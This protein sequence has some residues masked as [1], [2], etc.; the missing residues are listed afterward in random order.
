MQKGFIAITALALGALSSLGLLY[1]TTSQNNELCQEEMCYEEKLGT[2]SSTPLT[3][4]KSGNV[5][6]LNDS[7]GFYVSSGQDVCIDGGACLSTGGGGGGFTTSSA[8]FW[9]EDTRQLG[10]LSDVNTTTISI[11]D[12]LIWSGTEWL[13]QAQSGGSGGS[14]WLFGADQT[15]ITPSTTVGII[16]NASSTLSETTFTDSV[17][18]K[19]SGNDETTNSLSIFNSDGDAIMGVRDNVNVGVGTT[20]PQSRLHV[21]TDGTANFRLQSTGADAAATMGF[22]GYEAGG[23]RTWSFGDSWNANYDIALIN[24]GAGGDLILR[25]NTGDGGEIHFKPQNIAAGNIDF[26]GDLEIIGELTAT[27]ASANS[28]SGNLQVTGSSDSY[29]SGA[30]LAVGDTSAGARL[31]VKGAGATS[32]TNAFRVEDSGDNP[33]FFIRDDGNVGI[34]NAIPGYKLEVTGTTYLDGDATTTAQLYLS[35]YDCSGYG[36]SGKLTVDANGHVICADDSGGGGG[37]GGWWTWS[38]GYL[39]P[40]TTTADVLIGAN[41][42]TTTAK[43]EVIGDAYVSQDMTVGTTTEKGDLTVQSTLSVGDV[44]SGGIIRQGDNASRLSIFS[45]P[46]LGGGPSII[47]NASDATLYE[48]GMGLTYGGKAGTGGYFSLQHL[49]NFTYTNVMYASSS[50]FIGFHTT[51]PSAVVHIRGDGTTSATEALR[52][53]DSAGA[54]ALFVIRDDGSVGIGTDSPSYNL[55][56]TG[57]T[58]LD[59]GVTTTQQVYFSEYDCSGNTNSGKLTVDAN[60]HIVCGD[61]ISGGGGGGSGWWTWGTGYLYP[62]ST[63][64]DVLIGAASTSTTAKLEVIGET[65][66]SATTT[67]GDDLQVNS[68]IITVSKGGNTHHVP[69]GND[70]SAFVVIDKNNTANDASLLLADQGNLIWEIGTAGNNNLNGK[71]LQVQKAAMYLLMYFIWGMTTLEL[72]LEQKCLVVNLR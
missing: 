12:V 69:S 22:S 11:N 50:S 15:F 24:L 68:R 43:L 71:L 72:V 5:Y 67:I 47:M 49:D 58:Y 46:A 42:T 8:D 61:D 20:T 28:F 23:T 3:K 65:N 54:G 7:W 29:F 36:N 62:N 45:A 53:T 60:G 39:Y 19:G 10:Q 25:T 4:L 2:F 13:S 34:G 16:V 37:A 52:V 27:G 63:T 35:A 14:N 31:H 38:T 41:S 32:A 55:E 56:V 6:P 33:I 66:I 40:S 59:G 57:T 1:F 21:I 70:N 44:T 26:N 30:N 51:S 48:G 17:D 9:F 18:I 64:A